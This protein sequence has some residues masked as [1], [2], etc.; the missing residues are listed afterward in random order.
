MPAKSA[1][2]NL[3]DA[4]FFLSLESARSVRLACIESG[5]S[6]Q[7]V[8]RWRR[9]DEK[10]RN[11]WDDALLKAGDLLEEDADRRAVQGTLIPARGGG[12]RRRYSDALLLARLKAVKPDQYREPIIRVSR[13]PELDQYVA[14]EHSTA[15]LML[16]WVQQGRIEFE[17]LPD[18]LRKLAG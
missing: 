1:R 12:I 15:M 4:R 17:E 7:S 11:R 10:F 16:K 14:R 18:H 6:R 3:R 13:T 2:H 8:Y 5:Y 9:S